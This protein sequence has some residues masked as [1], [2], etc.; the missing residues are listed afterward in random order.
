[1]LSVT[2][3]PARWRSAWT[4]LKRTEKATDGWVARNIDR[5]VSRPIS[6]VLLWLGL[7]AD[8]ASWITLLVGLL[9][10]AIA[11]RPG[12][13]PLVAMGALFVAASILDG[14]DGEMARATLTESEAGARLDTIVDQV[15]Y[16]ACFVGMMIGWVREGGGRQALV[17]AAV[18]TVALVVSLLRAGLFVARYA[19]NA[20]F[21][22]VDRSV[23][24]A[25]R[26]SGGAGLRA[27]A[28]AFTLL[29]RD[30]FAVLFFFVALIGYR[31][32]FPALVGVGILIANLTFS[33]YGRELEA[34]AVA[35]RARG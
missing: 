1:V 19:P 4:L 30:A 22:F 25:A 20:S 14:V 9:A 2:S 29:R 3:F 12:Y 10:A 8:H 17:W 6:Y 28:S 27:A 26:D 23:R 32:L 35:E 18:L 15:T 5:H 33:C 21:V 24:R 34:A 16:V 31:V 7:A 11:A 13:V